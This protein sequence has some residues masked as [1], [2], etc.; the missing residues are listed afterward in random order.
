L[1][2][3]L[4]PDVIHIYKS[5]LIVIVVCGGYNNVENA[6]NEQC[7]KCPKRNNVTIVKNYLIIK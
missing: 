4:M 6:I 2:I 3:S 7:R 5:L 1:Q